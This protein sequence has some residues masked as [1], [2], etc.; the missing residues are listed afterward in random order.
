MAL[1]GKKKKSSEGDDEV[2]EDQIEATSYTPQPEKATKWFAHAR[3]MADSA[4]FETA[5]VYYASGLRFDPQNQEAINAMLQV[6]IKHSGEGGKRISSKAAKSV[7]GPEPVDKMAVA[8]LYWMSDL[9]NSTLAIKALEAICAAEQHSTGRILAA[10][11][12]SLVRRGK[13]PTKQQFIAVKDLCKELH[14]WDE[15]LA[16]GHDA[17]HLDPS[18]GSLDHEIKDITAQRAMAA[19]GYEEDAGAEGGFRKFIKDAD[20]QREIEEEESLAGAGGGSERA[21]ARAKERFLEA[22]DVAENVNRYGTMLRR[23]GTAES[24][25]EAEKVFMMCQSTGIPPISTIGFGRTVVS[26]DNRVPKPPASI[27]AFIAL[28][29]QSCSKSYPKTTGPP[30]APSFCAV[31]TTINVHKSIHCSV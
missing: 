22:P 2:N 16:A 1:F 10:H 17:M 30:G 4:N 3:T 19:G 11:V 26:S 9:Q 28:D 21:I 5:L 18:D 8:I 31:E 15:A 13:K 25:V 27:T 12:L 14:A 23:E 29:P 7:E 20:K 6:G 24:L